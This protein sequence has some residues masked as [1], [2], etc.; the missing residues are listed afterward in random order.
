MPATTLRLPLA[1][2]ALGC[3]I[4]AQAEMGIGGSPRDASSPP[5][6][7]RIFDPSAQGTATA[8]FSIEG[9]STGFVSPSRIT[10]EP[11]E[12]VL[13]VSDFSGQAVRVVPAFASGDVAPVRVLNPPGMGQPRHNVPMADHGELAVI[14]SNCCITTY[15]LHASG[16]NVAALR[17]ISWGGGSGSQTELEN[18]S[19]LIHL[20]ATDEYAVLDYVPGTSQSQIV[21]HARTSTGNVAPTRK[22]T[23]IALAGAAAM[24]YDPSSRLI[25][26]VASIDQ[27]TTST[28]GRVAVFADTAS[29]AAMPLYTITGNA[30]RLTQPWGQAFTGIA[31]DPYTRRIMVSSTTWS[32][33]LNAN[34]VVVFNDDAAGNVAPLQELEGDTLHPGYIGAPFAVPSYDVVFRNGFDLP[35]VL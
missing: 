5:M 28:Q 21:F 3:A 1:T 23:G 17:S 9:P 26:V 19:S 16:S 13:Y 33:S 34:R 22:I 29:G 8:A 35:P 24:T 7:I 32:P 20:H 31:H 10:Y 6:P 14:T 11:V 15:P 27:G 4:T 2:I 18:P 30:T 25:Y 12:R